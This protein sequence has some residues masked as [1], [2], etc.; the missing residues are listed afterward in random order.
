MSKVLVTGG[1]GYIGTV[2]TKE[3]V[4]K[5]YDVRVFDRLYFG[6][7]PLK[8]LE[9]RIEI[10]QGDIRTP[11]ESVLEGI[12]SVIHLAGFSNDPMA[13]FNPKVNM[14]MNVDGTKILAEACARIGINRFTYASSASIYDK[15]TRGSVELQDEKSDVEPK[16]AYSISKYKGEQKLLEVMNKYEEFCPVIL[17][18]GTVYGYSPRMRFDLVVNTFVKEAFLNGALNVFCQ[19]SQWRPLVDVKDVSRA[20]ITCMEADKE[21]V[22][23]QIFN[24][25]SSN[26]QVMDLAH[27]V[28]YALKDIKDLLVNVDYKEDRVDRSYRISGK[29]LEEMLG[30]RYLVSVGD[31]AK[32]MAE[33]IEG[34]EF[35]D[36][37][38]PKYYNIKW[39]ELLSDMHE[40]LE[41]MGG[42]VF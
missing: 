5:G 24:V 16:A 28:K 31:S 42:S 9:K 40:R 35:P 25:A 26:Y 19:G 11:S 20:H 29:K 7:E 21:L 17:R 6:R 15:G 8:E 39:I 27:R 37:N 13:E 4:Q 10:V 2:L 22:R 23:G 30:F 18:Q 38:D 32:D 34:G 14:E 36:L 1:A 33:R 3:L 12:S 41:E